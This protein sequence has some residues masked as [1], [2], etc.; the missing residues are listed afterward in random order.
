MNRIV[1]PTCIVIVSVV[2]SICVTR[3]MT[4]KEIGLIAPQ[5]F[6]VV[7]EPVELKDFNNP[8]ASFLPD[9]VAQYIVDISSNFGVD[10]TIVVSILEVENPLL[11][12]NALSKPNLN[13]SVDMGLFQLNARSLYEPNGF[14]E[15]WWPSTLPEF[16]EYNWKHNA[17][18]A[19]KYI[20]YLSDIFGYSNVFYIAAGY[21]AGD[22]RAFNEFSKAKNT[23]PLPEITKKRY[24]PQVENNYKK[25]LQS[26]QVDDL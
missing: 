14:L 7:S 12:P 15:R 3:Y 13:G 24:A 25:W 20:K 5:V 22:R 1:Y 23:E 19:I 21:N 16:D 10:P 17:Y 11:D 4:L 18:I 6:S 8:Y 9:E 26:F 2:I